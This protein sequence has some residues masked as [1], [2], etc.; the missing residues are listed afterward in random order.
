MRNCSTPDTK[1]DRAP[2][3]GEHP[4]RAPEGSFRGASSNVSPSHGGGAK[5]VAGAAAAAACGR[6]CAVIVALPG[7]SRPPLLRARAPNLYLDRVQAGGADRCTHEPR[8]KVSSPAPRG[9]RTPCSPRQRAPLQG[10]LRTDC[11]LHCGWKAACLPGPLSSRAG[12]RSRVGAMPTAEASSLALTPP[13]Y[14]TGGGRAPA[15][16]PDAPESR[17][18]EVETASGCGP[19]H[20]PAGTRPAGCRGTLLRKGRRARRPS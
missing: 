6:C 9:E 15:R 4:R 20:P 8:T 17:L 18:R 1:A 3:M 13:V 11:G 5:F 16:G 19:S 2:P 12:W 14:R 7:T 10:A